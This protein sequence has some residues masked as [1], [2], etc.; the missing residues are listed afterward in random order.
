MLDDKKCL[1]QPFFDIPAGSKLL[2]SAPVKNGDNQQSLWVF[3]VYR[4]AK[5]FCEAA[6]SV[7]H[8]FDTFRALPAMLRGVCRIIG[9][10]PLQTMKERLKTLQVWRNLATNLK[11]ENDD[12]FSRMDHGCAAVLKGKHLALLSKLAGEV[13]WPDASLHEELMQGFRLVGLQQ[14]SGVFDADVRP[15]F[16]TEEN[17]L[18]QSELIKPAL[19][20]RI[21]KAPS[22]DY[23]DELWQATMD[24]VVAKRWLDGLIR[25]RS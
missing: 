15:R 19:W 20:N 6:L 10:H 9:R 12:I 8:P 25:T 1:L 14:P 16:L 7:F 24:E 13:D 21:K 17:L 18:K 11:A 5:L 23:D 3:G 4:D 22:N 2:R